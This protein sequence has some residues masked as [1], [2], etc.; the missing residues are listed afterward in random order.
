MFLPLRG[1]F[2]ATSNQT[3]APTSKKYVAEQRI[4]MSN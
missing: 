3:G 2:V 1:P 4:V